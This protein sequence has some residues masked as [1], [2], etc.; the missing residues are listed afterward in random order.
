MRKKQIRELRRAILETYLSDKEKEKLYNEAK[1]EE[2]D[3]RKL[4][5][6]KIWTKGSKR[7]YLYRN[8]KRIFK[9]TPSNQKDVITV[10]G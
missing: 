9:N 8:G 4:F 10:G 1:N 5:R 2:G 3:T 7:D 6:Q